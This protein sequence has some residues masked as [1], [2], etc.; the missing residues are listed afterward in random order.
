MSN[1]FSNYKIYAQLAGDTY[2]N[3]KEQ[4]KI[5]KKRKECFLWILNKNIEFAEILDLYWFFRWFLYL[6]IWLAL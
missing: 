6:V 3:Y 4:N 1:K 5:F 2:L